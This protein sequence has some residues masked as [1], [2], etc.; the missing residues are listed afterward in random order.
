MMTT[1]I[2]QTVTSVT[3]SRT[4]WSCGGFCVATWRPGG[5]G[6]VIN[7]AIAD[8]TIP[9]PRFWPLMMFLPTFARSW[10][11]PVFTGQR[12][13]P[14][15]STSGARAAASDSDACSAAVPSPAA[16]LIFAATTGDTTLSAFTSV[17]GAPSAPGVGGRGR[18]ASGG[19]GGRVF[20]AALELPSIAAPV[21]FGGYIWVLVR[22]KL[23]CVLQCRHGASEGAISL[24]GEEFPAL[25]VTD[26]D[27]PIVFCTHVNTFQ[28]KHSPEASSET[29]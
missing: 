28:N 8:S 4:L 9:A 2:R 26:D 21:P 17:I 12:S 25:A 27:V 13:V 24:P 3:P 18:A 16:A 29:G 19:L 5:R 6:R 20:G 10:S 7:S 22:E 1:S 23:S 14:G 11:C 15:L